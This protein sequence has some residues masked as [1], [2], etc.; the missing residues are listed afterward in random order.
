MYIVTEL[1]E[2]RVHDD[3]AKANGERV[4]ALGDRRIPHLG[5]KDLAPLWLD[6]IPNTINRSWQGD[7]PHQQDTHD[8]I[9]KEGQ[10]IRCLAGALHTSSYDQKDA[11]PGEEQTQDQ[12]P[13]G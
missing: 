8:D 9:R 11:H 6:E 2:R 10:K 12:F 1:I 4:E 7:S 5:I 3:V 13:I